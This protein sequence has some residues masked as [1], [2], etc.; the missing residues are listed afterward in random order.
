MNRRE[1]G[2]A[3]IVTLL[4][5]IA[6]LMLGTSAAQLALQNEKAS[7]NDRDR[8]IALQAAEAALADAE[9]D[10][11]NSPDTSR[12]R[13]AMFSKDS[14]RGFP[15]DGESVCGAGENNKA[16]GLCE[17]RA[18]GRTPAWML[19]DF[20]DVS[21]ATTQSVP[22]GKFTGQRFQTGI[23]YQPG[24]LPRY[25]IEL[26]VFNAQGESADKPSYFYRITAIGYGARTVTQ[27]VLQA[28]YRK[29]SGMR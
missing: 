2:A 9:L 25:V 27:A 26:M 24:R 19:V 10:I 21:P 5:L 13:S 14:A 11:E 15:A 22:F 17:H 3:L 12:S 1:G 23:G 8:Q 20:N 16:L 4:M 29:E 7:R 6:V 18:E 28:M